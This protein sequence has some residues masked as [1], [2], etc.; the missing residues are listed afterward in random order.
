MYS[1]V[2]NAEAA[3]EKMTRTIAAI[4][5]ALA[6]A[7]IDWSEFW[8]TIPD[9]EE[10]ELADWARTRHAEL[11]RDRAESKPLTREQAILNRVVAEVYAFAGN[12]HPI[13][14]FL[15]LT[16]PDSEECRQW[17]QTSAEWAEML[18]DSRRLSQWLLPCMVPPTPERRRRK[19]RKSTRR[20]RAKRAQKKW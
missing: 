20:K 6:G 8:E 19:S 17:S 16:E 14:D 1:M 9:H 10:F 7:E 2:Y 4:E 3:S 12:P 13:A 5:D 18:P 11:A 15:T